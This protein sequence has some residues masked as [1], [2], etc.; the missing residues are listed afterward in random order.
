[1]SQAQRD[2]ERKQTIEQDVHGENQNTFEHVEGKVPP[3]PYEP[4][5]EERLP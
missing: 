4:T 5:K 2:Q 3:K 1:M